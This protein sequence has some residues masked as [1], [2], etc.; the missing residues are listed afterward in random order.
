MKF[1]YVNKHGKEE[2]WV[3][4][5][6]VPQVVYENIFEKEFPQKFDTNQVG[7]V[8]MIKLISDGDKVAYYKTPYKTYKFYAEKFYA[9]GDDGFTP[10]IKVQVDDMDLSFGEFFDEYEYISDW[11]NYKFTVKSPEQWIECDFKKAY[12]LYDS[13]A[14][15]RCEVGGVIQ[16]FNK[17]SYELRSLA[18]I[19]SMR[20]LVAEWEYKA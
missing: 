1:E 5:Q 20:Q 3:N 6:M 10:D 15:V 13:G 9:E 7:F 2:F 16:E 8:D 11:V 19:V 14:T 18:E 17:T 4:G 12:K